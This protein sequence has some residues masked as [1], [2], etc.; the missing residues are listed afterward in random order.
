MNLYE[1]KVF[2]IKHDVIE[3]CRKVA[4]IAAFVAEQ[5]HCSK[6]KLAYSKKQLYIT[7]LENC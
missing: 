1:R 3:H 4:G 2:V 6:K 7:T 5:N